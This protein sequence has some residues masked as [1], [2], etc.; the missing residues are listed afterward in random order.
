[1]TQEQYDEEAQLVHLD[2]ARA[3]IEHTKALTKLLQLEAQI[4]EANLNK[5]AE[6]K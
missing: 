3:N 6:G 5:L 4:K 2:T 1:M